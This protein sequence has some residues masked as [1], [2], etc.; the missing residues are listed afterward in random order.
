MVYFLS[1][2]WEF[3]LSTAIYDSGLSSETQGCTC[4]VHRHISAT[5]NYH[6]LTCVDRGVIVIAI[7]LHEVVSCE[8][9]VC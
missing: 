9:L 8:E 2:C 3:L 5:D 1:T 4:C 7:C 6:L